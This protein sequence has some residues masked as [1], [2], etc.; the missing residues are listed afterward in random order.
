[1]ITINRLTKVISVEIVDLIFTGTDGT[2]RNIY[3]FDTD[4]FRNSLNAIEDSEGGI[5]YVDSH[6]HNTEI[7]LSGV[8]YARFIEFINGYSISFEEGTYAVNF[9]NSNNNI[10][11][12][13]VINS[14]S[15]RP[16]NSAGLV[17]VERIP[18]A[19]QFWDEVL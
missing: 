1:M 9:I 8:T 18:T 11:D 13:A 14:V 2:G 5:V 10:A 16:Q 19:Q 4:A 12:V 17:V 15:I 3:S 7:V 6:I